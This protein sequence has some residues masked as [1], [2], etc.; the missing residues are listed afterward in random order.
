[1]KRIKELFNPQKITY[2]GKCYIIDTKNNKYVIKPHDK[3]LESLFTYL[4]SR[5]FSDYPVIFDKYDNNYIYEYLNDTNEP[6]NQKAN[7]L[8]LTISNLHNQTSH[9]IKIVKNDLDKIYH[10]INDNILY[11]ENYYNKLYRQI[12]NE[13]YPSPSHYLLIRNQSKINGLIKYLKDELNTWYK[14]IKLSEE[15]RVVYCHNNLSIDHYIGHKMISW[16]NY[17]V[18]SPILDIINL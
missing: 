4:S 16:D 3:D 1:M 6:I 8:A 10:Q 12:F 7:D 9:N 18:D 13:E 5:N 2:Q 17:T 14:N 11:I 15:T